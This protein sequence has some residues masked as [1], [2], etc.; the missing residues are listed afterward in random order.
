VNAK[1]MWLIAAVGV[2]VFIGAYF[3]GQLTRGGA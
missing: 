2:L 1:W 3:L